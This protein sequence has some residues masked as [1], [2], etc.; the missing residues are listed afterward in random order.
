MTLHASFYYIIPV[1][2]LYYSM[3]I[4]KMPVIWDIFRIKI[5][6]ISKVMTSPKTDHSFEKV[7]LHGLIEFFSRRIEC[8]HLRWIIN[9]WN[10]RQNCNYIIHF[11]YLSFLN[12]P[13]NIQTK[14][15]WTASKYISIHFLSTFAYKKRLFI[16]VKATL[17]SSLI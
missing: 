6:K 3:V 12:I 13:S 5:S 8:K 16:S 15:I 4:I 2:N 17:I 7:F 1:P 9:I 11:C 14:S 10:Q